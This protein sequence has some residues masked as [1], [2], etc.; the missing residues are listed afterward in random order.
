MKIIK[1]QRLSLL[2][3]TY[4]Y[5]GKFYLAANIMA[6][7]S[8]GQPQRLLSEQSMWKFVAEA[9]GK[10]AVL[11]MGLPKQ[12]G[13][14]VMHGKCFAPKGR[15]VTQAV[16]KAKVAG[17][18]KTLAVTGNRVWK[19]RG[20]T[21]IISEPEP[22]S[23]VDL[24]YSNA[25]GGE[26]FANNPVGKGMPPG[27]NALQHSLPNI[28]SPAYPI[29]FMDDRPQPASFAP[30]D[31]TWPQRFSKAGTH[32]EAWLQTRF[33]GFAADMDWSIFNTAQPDQIL[34][35]YF[36]GAE[37]FE[38][39]GMHPEK[40]V[41]RGTLPGC[42]MRCFVTEKGDARMALRDVPTRAETLVLFPGAERAVLIFRGVTEITTDDGA[43][44]AHI[45]IGSEDMN[46][47]KPVAHY[48]TVLRQ[49]LDRKDGAIACLIDEPLLH[50]MPDSNSGG[51][52]SDAE[53]M[54]ILVRPKGLLRKNLLRKSEKMLADIKVTLQKTREELIATCAAAGLPAPDLTGIDKALAQ[55][56]PPDPPAP[57][58]EELP[59]LREKLEKML[60]DGKA[61]GIVKQAEAE[62]TLRQTCVEQKLDYDK[63]VA[64]A[65]RESA[66]PPKPIASKTVNQLQTTADE[67]QSLGHPSADLNAK[68]AG[69][70]LQDQLSQADVAVMGAYRQFVHVYPPVGSL[71]GEAAQAIRQDVMAAVERGEKLAGRDFSGADFSGLKLVGCDFSNALM[72][73]V[74]FSM[75]DLTGS[76]FSKAVLARAIFT[77]A[78]LSQT[79]FTD[80][81]LGFCNLAGVHA[82]DANFTGAKLAGADLTGVNLRGA[83]LT[84]ADLMGAKLVG[85]DFSGANA[86]EVK[87]IQVNLLAKEVTPADMEGLPELPMQGAK[88]IG[89]KLF[90]AMFLN[91][92]MD[93]ADFTGACLDQATFLTAIGSRVNFSCASLKGLCVVKDSKLQS[94][95]FSGA[96]MEK[97]NFRCTDLH[98]SVF[99]NANL[100]NC[101]LSECVL[102]SADF[103]LA[104][105]PNVQLVKAN[106]VGADFS[107]ANLQ[108][109]N[110][111]KANMV[112]TLFWG[113]NLF[114]ADFLR[115]KY[116]N[117]TVFERANRGKTL[118]RKSA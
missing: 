7:F 54:D 93:N 99:K 84:K 94:A 82:S 88:F 31:F 91:C 34:P 20:L 73:G 105:A 27:D 18:E 60:A 3:R 1:P 80:A 5:E 115:C 30:L 50:A 2:T 75:A 23:S 25:F 38:V 118:L 44:I 37:A 85:A 64:D 63:L 81:N 69:V 17:L 65:R 12:R 13:E 43:D 16:V 89:T 108:Q 79:N 48:Q 70:K 36:S 116:D 58:L 9:L 14:F 61:E 74:N 100:N 62:A 47:A 33:P 40:P 49:R 117:T 24:N 67:L 83:D 52:A 92:R 76:N 101:D 6:F 68:L 19:N 95:N 26:G 86:A 51:D 102:T 77:N 15:A 41:V 10:D 90:K 110:L 45:L 57:R 21:S 28:E 35:A 56:I 78:T 103:K 46:A 96:D 66:G 104:A 22:F 112:G 98:L 109:A 42:A 8:F 55:T 11:D 107:G 113:C 59:A 87:F 72:E 53:A 71:E 39:Q 29:V 4:E 114:M 32:D 106:L 111:Q 97:A